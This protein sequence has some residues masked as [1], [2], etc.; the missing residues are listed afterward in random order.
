MTTKP[1]VT[2]EPA[3]EVIPQDFGPRL[4]ELNAIVRAEKPSLTNEEVRREALW[5]FIQEGAE[6]S[7]VALRNGIRD[8]KSTVTIAKTF[9]DWA[10]VKP[11]KSTAGEQSQAERIRAARERR[12]HGAGR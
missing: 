5:K 9:V 10:D 4:V 7:V 8:P 2:N 1:N 6:E 12:Q 11:P 3:P